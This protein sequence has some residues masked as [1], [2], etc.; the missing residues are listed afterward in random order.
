MLLETEVAMVLN[1]GVSV[2]LM[3]EVTFNQRLKGGEGITQSLR[4]RAFQEEGGVAAEAP[5]E[6]PQCVQGVE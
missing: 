3:E 2:G 5:R 6:D 4:G 1:K